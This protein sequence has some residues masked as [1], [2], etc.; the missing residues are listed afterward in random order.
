MDDQILNGDGSTASGITNVTGFISELPSVTNPTAVTTWENL[1]RRVHGP[2]GRHQF[3]YNVSDLRAIIGGAG[4][5]VHATSCS[6][7]QL[8]KGRAIAPINFMREKPGRNLRF[9]E[10]PGRRGKRHSDRHR[11]AHFLSRTQRGHADMAT[12]CNFIV[13]PYSRA[14]HGQVRLTVTAFFNFKILRET[15]WALFKTKHA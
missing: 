4:V 9:V 8:R 13:D 11:S 1:R 14:A 3:S 15:G 6:G 10:D 5:R 12:R 2:S 7:R